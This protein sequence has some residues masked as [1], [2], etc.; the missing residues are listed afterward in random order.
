MSVLQWMTAKDDSSYAVPK[1]RDGTPQAFHHV[2]IIN[3]FAAECVIRLVCSNSEGSTDE[4]RIARL[5]KEH[6]S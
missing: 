5:L 4:S 6:F 3:V 2:V 1:G